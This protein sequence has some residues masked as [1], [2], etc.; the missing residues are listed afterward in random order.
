M[1]NFSRDEEEGARDQILML[2][3]Y[4]N[5][6]WSSR[7]IQ[8][9]GI[10]REAEEKTDEIS[11]KRRKNLLSCNFIVLD[12]D[13]R[14]CSDP[15]ELRVHDNSQNSSLLTVSISACLPGLACSSESQQFIQLRAFAL[16]ASF[17][18]S[19][20]FFG[21]FAFEVLSRWLDDV[22]R[23]PSRSISWTLA[24]ASRGASSSSSRLA[25]LLIY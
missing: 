1:C 25:R 8:L 2:A 5:S 15:M 21:M 6:S 17:L 16:L 14:W 13:S 18:G 22:T 10:I 19:S 7:A 9:C 3:R 11:Q 23:Y 4:F 12:R 20:L 24:L